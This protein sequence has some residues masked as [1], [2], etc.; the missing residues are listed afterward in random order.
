MC[1]RL[2]NSLP[3]TPGDQ[4]TLAVTSDDNKVV[5]EGWDSSVGSMSVVKALGLI[6]STM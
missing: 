4:Q 1:K 3:Y 5:R 6:P 2:H